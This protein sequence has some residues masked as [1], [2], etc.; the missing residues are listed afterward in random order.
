[1]GVDISDVALMDHTFGKLP[2]HLLI[3]IFIRVPVSQWVHIACVKQNWAHLFRGECL[4]KCVLLKT[5]PSVDQGDQWAG[6]I[7]RGSSKRR[8][9]ALY[10][11]K[12]VSVFDGEI[13]EIMGHTYLF[14]KEQ[15]ELSVMPPASGILH[16]TIIDQFIACGKSRD[17][18]MSSLPKSG[19]QLL[20]VWMKVSKRFFYL[21]VLLRREMFSFHTRTRDLTKFNGGYL[22]S[23]SQIFE[24]ASMEWITM[25]YW[26]VL[27]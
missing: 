9:E 25:T 21:C 18:A 23:F 19:L 16:G 2:D 5:W 11:S 7:G 26:H 27:S 20:T 1:M 6:P 14:L 10:V 4:W 17:K 13:D 15:L 22:R 8:Y 3:E 24:I 12:H